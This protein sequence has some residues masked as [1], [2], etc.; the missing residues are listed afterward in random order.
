MRCQ[1]RGSLNAAGVEPASGPGALV[2]EVPYLASGA[3]H[4][5]KALRRTP[6]PQ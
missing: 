6:C 4:S 1:V 5:S 3:H 2:G